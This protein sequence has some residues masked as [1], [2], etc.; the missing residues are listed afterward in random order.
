MKMVSLVVCLLVTSPFLQSADS[1]AGDWEGV[2]K[3]GEIALR[4]RLHVSGDGD[5]L[6]A[7][8]DSV[9]QNVFGMR[10]DKIVRKGR[11]VDFE[12]AEIKATYSGALSADG[13]TIAGSWSQLGM[14]LPVD[15][16]K[17]GKTPQTTKSK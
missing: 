17:Q 3:I 6:Q 9:D 5:K 7:T 16:K 14:S 10:V 15:F 13:S 12:L 8:F 2:I 4:L 11:Q 1:A